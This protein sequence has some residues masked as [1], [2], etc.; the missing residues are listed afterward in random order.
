[1]E[2]RVDALERILE[3]MNRDREEDRRN[4]EEERR[5]RDED[6]KERAIERERVEARFRTLEKIVENMVSKPEGINGGESHSEEIPQ[7]TGEEKTVN[8]DDTSGENDVNGGEIRVPRT[9]PTHT[10]RW[11]KLDIPIFQGDEDAYSWIQKLERY[12]KLKGATEEEKIQAIMVALDGKALSWYQWW[13]TCNTATT[14]DKFKEALLARFQIATASSP[15]AA[16]LAL[17]QDGTVEEFVEQFERFAGMLRGVDEEHYMDIF[18]N[19]LKEEVSAEIKLYEPGTLAKMVKKALMVEQKNLAVSKAGTTSQSRYN[20]AYKPSYKPN[21]FQ[22]SVTVETGIKNG[23][24]NTTQSVQSSSGSVMDRSVSRTS[25]GGT[26]KR[27]SGDEMKETLRKGECFRC[28]EKFGPNHI[29]KNK[30][31]RVMLMAE[32][33][34]E[35]DIETLSETQEEIEEAIEL[36]QLSL[37]SIQGISTRK[38]LKVWGILNGTTIVVLIDCGATHNFI[39]KAMAKQ[40]GLVITETSTSTVEVGDG[41]KVQGSGV[42]RKVSV[43]IPGIEVVQ[44][45][46]L[47]ELRGVDVVLG[48]EWLA[49]LG[50][51]KAN[52]EKLT[53]KFK[54]GGQKVLLKGEPELLKRGVSINS[55]IKS[56]QQGEGYVLHCQ[57]L[58]QEL[59]TKEE[60]PAELQSVLNQFPVLFESPTVLPPRRRHD[61]AIHLQEGASIP[62]I[63]SYRYPHYQKNE[64]EKLVTEMLD[65][66]IIRPSISPYSSPVILVRKKDGSWRFCVDYRALNKVTIPNKF[67]IPVIDELLDEIGPA[68]VFSKIDLKLSYHQIMM[69][70]EDIEKTAFRTHEGHYEFIV[71]PFGL[72]NAPS[73]FQSLMNEVLKPVLR[74]CALVFFDDIDAAEVAIA[75][76]VLK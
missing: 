23:G 25:R 53:L 31:F 62:N 30:Q 11:R 4:R 57:M 37:Y 47:F 5:I 49:G 66:G 39:S 15:F 6:R 58:E 46:Y 9:E 29:S 13:E 64:I 26:F 56:L 41:H 35:E 45:F 24:G 61:H 12:F 3:S 17:K 20:N 19:G 75:L 1:M 14:W 40:L 10:E 34:G 54:V 28:E 70:E 72:T 60:T 76:H 69:K 51:I 36:K 22:K 27:L 44:D 59:A 52:F 73:T 65:A 32:D 18:I 7:K 74:K 21:S 8:G 67:P 55:A 2:S 38:S 43:L 50:D 42:C 16:L 68:R 71:M 63:R 48:L 33:D